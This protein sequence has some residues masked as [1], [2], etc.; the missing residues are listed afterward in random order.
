VRV[1]LGTDSLA[2]NDVLDCRH[3]AAL[4]IDTLGASPLQALRMLGDEAEDALGRPFGRT[5]LASGA[6]ADFAAHRTMAAEDAALEDLLRGRQSAA[7]VWIGGRQ[8]L[9]CGVADGAG[10]STRA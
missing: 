9:L 10:A 5:G 7:G 3:E 8:V 4:A 1:V 2:S 6:R